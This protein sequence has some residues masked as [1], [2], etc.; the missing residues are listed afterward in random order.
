MEPQETHL[1]GLSI[2]KRVTGDHP[3]LRGRSKGSGR[4]LFEVLRGGGW[5]R[6]KLTGSGPWSLHPAC[7]DR[8]GVRSLGGRGGGDGTGFPS[9]GI[10]WSLSSYS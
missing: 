4:G 3:G 6:P 10:P 2:S 7:W 8:G 1:R 5:S 9:Q